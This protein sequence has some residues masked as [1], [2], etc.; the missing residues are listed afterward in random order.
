MDLKRTQG[1]VAQ[2][3]P[4]CHAPM[5]LHDSVL[6]LAGKTCALRVR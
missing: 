2:A 4:G 3:S 5:Q 6:S 1:Q